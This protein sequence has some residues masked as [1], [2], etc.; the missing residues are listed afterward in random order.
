MAYLVLYYLL[1]IYTNKRNWQQ[2]DFICCFSSSLFFSPLFK[3]VVVRCCYLYC[4]FFPETTIGTIVLFWRHRSTRPMPLGPRPDG[5][6]LLSTKLLRYTKFYTPLFLVE[7]TTYLYTTRTTG[8]DTLV[9]STPQLSF[10]LS[11]RKCLYVFLLLR[12]VT[13]FCRLL[14]SFFAN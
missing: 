7:N 11:Q 13:V 14:S 4:L 9:E 2:V 3:Q 12:Y 1:A 5:L 10:F 8:L 6:V